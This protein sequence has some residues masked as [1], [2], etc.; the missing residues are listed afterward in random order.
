MIFDKQRSLKNDPDWNR[1]FKSRCRQIPS[2]CCCG[3]SGADLHV[4]VF[5]NPFQYSKP[6]G[7][8]MI[9]KVESLLND[10]E[11]GKLTRR[12][13][14]VSLAALAAG[15]LVSPLARGDDAGPQSFPAISVNH[16]T[17]HVPDLR[18]TSRFYQEF[19][20]MPLRQQS[21]TVH[22][23]GV[24]SSFFGIEQHDNGPAALDHYDFGI[25]HFN[26]DQIRAALRKRNLEIQ[27]ERSS[28]S[29]KFRDPDGFLVQVNGSDYVGHVS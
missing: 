12:Q 22:I 14:A 25:A 13:V 19:F 3:K 7:E 11:S 16:V 9:K 28:E 26:A 27:D 29:F 2:S 6:K 10:F 8:I 5:N 18:R 4:R 24:G 17:V 21:P 20:Q 15:A 23:L 1:S